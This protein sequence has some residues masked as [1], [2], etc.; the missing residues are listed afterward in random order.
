MMELVRIS[1]SEGSGLF[2][3]HFP[4]KPCDEFRSLFD[5]WSDPELLENFFEANTGDLQQSR[6]S[7]PS[8]DD[9]VLW[10]IEEAQF[11]LK[12]LYKRAQ[13]GQ[14]EPSSALQTLFRPLGPSDAR[15][16]SWQ[17]S[18]VYG[19]H[20]KGW[21]RVYAIRLSANTFIVTGGAIKL[22]QRM[23]ERSHT[24]RELVKLE[25]VKEFL[26]RNGIHD[27]DFEVLEINQ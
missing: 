23:E 17:R 12:V 10:T 25:K 7:Y 18:K 9:A 22:T 3:V 21:L 13:Q 20:H 5:Y 19:R 14:R 1:P 11:L 6:Y 2:A 16:L 24:E 26:R 15:S 8:I 27:G 4:E